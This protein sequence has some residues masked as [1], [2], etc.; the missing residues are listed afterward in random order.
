MIPY[1]PALDPLC[2]ITDPVILERIVPNKVY[3]LIKKKGYN[4]LEIVLLAPEQFVAIQ[5]VGK[6]KIVLLQDF[7][8]LFATDAYVEQILH[9]QQ[10][11]VLEQQQLQ[12]KK[13]ATPEYIRELAVEWSNDTP[14]LRQLENLALAVVKEFR[15]IAEQLPK[16]TVKKGLERRTSALEQYFG[17]NGPALSFK[18]IGHLVGRTSEAV[19]IDLFDPS[20]GKFDLSQFLTG[21]KAYYGLAIPAGLVQNIQAFL[22]SFVHTPIDSEE[23]KLLTEQKVNQ[24]L[25]PFKYTITTLERS[26]QDRYLLVKTDEIIYVRAHFTLLKNVLSAGNPL[27]FEQVIAALKEESAARK[28]NQLNKAVMQLGINESLVESL[29]EHFIDFERFVADEGQ[30]FFRLSWPSLPS[31]NAQATYILHEAEGLMSLA[32]IEQRIQELNL[33][34]QLTTDQPDFKIK[35]S[36]YIAPVGKLGLWRYIRN[37]ALENGSETYA[38]H[39]SELLQNTF[40]GKAS[41]TELIQRVDAQKFPGYNEITTRAYLN[42]FARRA[43]LDPNLF[44]HE[45][46]LARFS[47][48]QVQ[49]K[50]N[51]HFQ[52]TAINIIVDILRKEQKLAREV[53]VSSTLAELEQRGFRIAHKFVLHPILNKCIGFNFIEEVL[54]ETDGQRYFYLVPTELEHIDISRIGLKQEPEYKKR[55]RATVVAYLKEVGEAA[56]A[57]LKAAFIDILPDNIAHNNFYKTLSSEPLFERFQKGASGFLRLKTDAASV[58]HVDN[59]A[60]TQS[61]EVQ[62]QPIQIFRRPAFDIQRLRSLAVRELSNRV[63]LKLTEFQIEDGF[64]AFVEILHQKEQKIWVRKM[65]EAVYYVFDNHSDKFDKYNCITDLIT[66]YESFVKRLIP[67]NSF[68]KGQYDAIELVPSLKELIYYK[69]LPYLHRTDSRKLKFSRL[70][71]SVIFLSNKYR[72]DRDHDSLDFSFVNIKEQI[73]DY[74]GLYIYTALLVKQ[75][76]NA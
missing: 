75:V 36:P 19:R 6:G 60:S 38:Q 15:A 43:K 39:L 76:P 45:D 27:T 35:K 52:N 23:V 48:I 71:S 65:L 59:N 33:E 26:L 41:Y 72:H 29:L 22:L 46:C 25:A 56:L 21:N 7:Q 20:E 53:L 13:S 58:V 62:E 11:L 47:D 44:I 55:L 3:N 74:F 61:T 17:I 63:E 67:S 2:E 66:S 5:G 37:G 50:Q 4:L 8:A 18:E 30:T 64:D 69:N 68:V 12:N 32:A 57:E 70:L 1:R 34:N 14:F 16:G 42:T 9:V 73:A 49:P 31:V 40:K 28:G 24:L 51:K 10:S 54:N